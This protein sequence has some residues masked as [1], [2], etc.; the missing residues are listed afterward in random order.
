MQPITFD[1]DVLRITVRNGTP[2]SWVGVTANNLLL[3]I[4]ARSPEVG[5]RWPFTR[6]LLADV[7]WS[8]I[9]LLLGPP[10]R[11][12]GTKTHNAAEWH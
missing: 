6:S 9:P 1:F 10:L 5:L 11:Y 8:H 4:S 3:L 12:A 2:Y 7:D